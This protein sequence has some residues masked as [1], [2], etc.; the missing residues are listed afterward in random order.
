MGVGSRF[1]DADADRMELGFG[2]KRYTR[3]LRMQLSTC[4][5]SAARINIVDFP[6]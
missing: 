6:L 4:A 5:M 3:A 2:A 1:L